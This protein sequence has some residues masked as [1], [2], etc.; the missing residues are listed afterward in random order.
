METY[1]VYTDEVGDLLVK[2]LVKYKYVWV[3]VNKTIYTDDLDNDKTWFGV[4]NDSF[5]ADMNIIK[6]FKD[7]QELLDYLN[8]IKLTLLITGE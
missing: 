2:D 7:L 5:P 8:E 1:I 4:P 3:R 6:T